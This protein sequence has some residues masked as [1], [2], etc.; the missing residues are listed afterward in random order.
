MTRTQSASSFADT[1]LREVVRREGDP[2]RRRNLVE[3]HIHTLGALKEATQD[4]DVSHQRTHAE[5]KSKPMRVSARLST[6]MGPRINK[7]IHHVLS[8]CPLMTSVE[9]KG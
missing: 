6:R 2:T 8:T 1:T 4:G 7:V 9:A 5:G 3:D